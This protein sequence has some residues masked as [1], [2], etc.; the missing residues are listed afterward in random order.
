VSILETLSINQNIALG[1][2]LPP[3][4]VRY[5]QQDNHGADSFCGAA[6]AQMVLASIGSGMIG[7][8]VLFTHS[9]AHGVLDPHVDWDTAPDGLTATLNQL[10]P[11]GFP[12]DFTLWDLPSEDAIGRKLCWSIHQYRIAPIALIMGGTHWVVVV[13]YTA[14]DAPTSAEDTSYNIESFDI[15]DPWPPT[16]SGGHPPPHSTD[17]SDLCG[18]GSN[19]GNEHGKLVWGVDH[20]TVLEF[21]HWEGKILAIGD[22]DSPV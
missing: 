3:H 17:G 10:K 11:A 5:H 14:S 13:G 22:P 19:R 7:Q 20:L 12:Y 15:F 18:T 6:S 4:G 2:P 8:D 21:G 1:R 9:R 16:S